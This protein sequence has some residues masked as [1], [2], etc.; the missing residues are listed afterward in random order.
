M[1]NCHG[2]ALQIHTCAIMHLAGQAVY[3]SHTHADDA[4][5]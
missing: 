2:E 5:R 3:G 1:F 4:L